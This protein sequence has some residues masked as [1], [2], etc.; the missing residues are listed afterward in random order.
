VSSPDPIRV[1]VG[2]E[3]KTLVPYL[4]LRHSIVSRT[5]QAVEVVEMGDFDPWVV[6]PDVHQGTGFSL[7]RW[8]IPQACHFQG[9]ALYLDADQIVL[10]DIAELWRYREHGR[11]IACCYRPDKSSAMLTGVSDSPVPQTSVMVI[12]C[13]RCDPAAWDVRAIFGR[14]RA[15]GPPRSSAAVRVYQE[16][17][18]GRLVSDEPFPLDPRWNE[19]NALQADSKLLHYTIEW[20]QPWYQPDH[21][22]SALWE[23]ELVRAI[24]ARQVTAEHLRNAIRLGEAGSR[25]WRKFGGL[26]PHFKKYIG[27][28]DQFA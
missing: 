25:D 6:P 18:H 5:N 15:A 3:A 23:A 7:R 11:T 10:A 12:N 16:V 17:M 21:P 24:A 13:D 19:F 1:F 9:T 20:Q 2:T 27:L 28:A 14:I 26:S 22:L 4:V 8:M